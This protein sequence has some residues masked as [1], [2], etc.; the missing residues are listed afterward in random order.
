[1]SD[2]VKAIPEG[3]TTLTP[4]LTVRDAA[5]A[6]EFYKKAFGAVE[7]GRMPEPNGKRLIHAAVRIGESILMLVDAFP[8]FGGRSPDELGG[9]PVTIHVYSEDTDAAVERAVAAGA[10]V[11]MPPDDMFWGDR[12]A[13]LTDPFGHHWSIATHIR[14]MSEEEMR[15]AAAAAFSQP[16]K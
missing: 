2:R 14:D 9:S 16:R 4:H 13:R 12:Y 11:T 6:I 15:E 1:M 8:E 10:T 5:A 7:L 3:F